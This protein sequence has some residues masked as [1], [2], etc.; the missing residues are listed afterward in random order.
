MSDLDAKKR[1]LLP[2]ARTS[3]SLFGWKT[4]PTKSLPTTK[5]I[6]LDHT[7]VS[8][9]ARPPQFV[10]NAGIV[11]KV[12][13]GIAAEITSDINGV[14]EAWAAATERMQPRRA[15]SMILSS[16]NSQLRIKLVS[17]I[18]NPAHP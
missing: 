3:N 14:R 4:W 5:I 13:I 9:K 10:E 18:M 17:E 15:W 16:G 8:V 6:A 7:N 12:V 1:T 2:F 11:V